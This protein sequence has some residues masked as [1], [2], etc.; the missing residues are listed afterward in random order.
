MPGSKTRDETTD[1][2]A[3]FENKEN[4]FVSLI[5][6]APSKAALR[7]CTNIVIHALL[8]RKDD[9]ANKLACK[10]SL[11]K[12]IPAE[13]DADTKTGADMETTRIKIVELL[14]TI[15]EIR[16]K[17]A[18]DCESRG[19]ETT[20]AKDDE[21]NDNAKEAAV[22]KRSFDDTANA[23]ADL[24]RMVGGKKLPNSP[25]GRELRDILGLVLL[26]IGIG[27]VFLVFQNIQILENI[28][29]NTIFHQQP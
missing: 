7:K 21:D 12:I 5:E 25:A 27:I 1:W 4:G 19:T 11:E 18:L 20:T 29:Q 10:K 14:R 2:E 3:V 17:K 22:E 24:C 23:F 9:A 13:A 16:K 6:N 28:W 15:K 8:R 26:F